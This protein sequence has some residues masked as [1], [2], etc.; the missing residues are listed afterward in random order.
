MTQ[1][2]R[3]RES[4]TSLFSGIA[5]FELG[6]K[7]L[8]Y[9][10]AVFCERNPEA[11][12]VLKRGLR[13]GGALAQER[14]ATFVDDI[15][16]TRELL[17]SIP[18]DSTILTAGFPCT[19][20]SQAGRT[21]GFDGPQSGL[22]RNALALIA[23]RRETPTPFLHV[24]LENVPNW[25]FLHGG[26]YME[27]VV[28]TFEGLGYR[29]AYRTIDALAFGLPQRRRRLFLYATLEG[30][31]RNVL[32]VGNEPPDTRVYDGCVRAHGFYWTE[33]NNGIGWGEDCVPTLKGGSGLGIPS[34]PAILT[35]DG[36]VR[37][38]RIEAAEELQ[39]FA[40]GWTR[41]DPSDASD[42]VALNPRKRWQ[43]VGN[44]VNV[45]VS[46]W[47]AARLSMPGSAPIE[48]GSPLARG[49]S[50]PAAAYGLEKGKRYGLTSKHISEWPVAAQRRPLEPFLADRHDALSY[51]A[52][53]GF[54]TRYLASPL[55]KR[56]WLIECLR[57]HCE[58]CDP[59]RGEGDGEPLARLAA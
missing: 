31:P 32:F 2:T 15:G 54:L 57:R 23:A 59:R 21:R 22:V 41:F 28:S 33:G 55:E 29:W 36:H 26:A 53:H 34:A 4:I 47:L 56:D 51:K 5:G 42:G 40:P 48:A 16:K 49:A 7:A 20:L 52:A 44:A 24:F 46:T 19:D 39:G 50:F 27:E 18:K 13:P 45:E 6:F 12:A 10:T 38:P 14:P 43:L 8:G 11:I 37:V 30:D 9:E 25:R 1:A 17:A 3:R 35:T 58:R